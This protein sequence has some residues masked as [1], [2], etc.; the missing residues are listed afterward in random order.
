VQVTGN[1][2]SGLAGPKGAPQTTVTRSSSVRTD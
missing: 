2:C 1:R